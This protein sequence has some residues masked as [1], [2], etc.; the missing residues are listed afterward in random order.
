MRT[1]NKK[2]LL[3]SVV[4]MMADQHLIELTLAGEPVA[5][6]VLVKRHRGRVEA[7]AAQFLRGSDREDCVQETFLKA[8]VNLNELRDTSKF[9]A[10]VSVIARNYCLD[11]IRRSAPVSSIDDDT[12]TES[13]PK[14]IPCTHPGPCAEIMRLEDSEHLRRGI[15]RLSEKYRMILDMRYFQDCDYI[16]ISRRL[17]KPVGTVKSLIHRAHNQLKAI[18][19]EGSLQDS[20]AVVH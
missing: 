11:T 17:N 7:V 20:K 15:T 3:R 19:L 8:L 9:G 5:Y 10:W 16:T 14:Q 1:V 6:D 4:E 12:R 18:M 2:K 13:R